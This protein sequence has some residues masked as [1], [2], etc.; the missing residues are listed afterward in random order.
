[1]AKKLSV[2]LLILFISLAASAQNNRA[3]LKNTRGT[4]QKRGYSFLSKLF[5]SNIGQ[6]IGGGIG[7]SKFSGR[8][9]RKF[10][11]RT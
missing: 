3:R 5:Y 8:I 4:V 7:T 2:V 11:Y 1:M 10:G 6:E 9:R